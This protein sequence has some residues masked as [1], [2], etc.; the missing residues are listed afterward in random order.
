[1]TG[2]IKRLVT[3]RGFGFLKADDGRE[4]FFHRSGLSGISIYDLVEGDPVTFEEEVSVK[5]PRAKTVRLI[6]PTAA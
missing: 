6:V 3:D 2:T 5:G 1:M 4:L